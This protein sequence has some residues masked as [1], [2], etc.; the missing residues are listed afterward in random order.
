MVTY[1][2]KD[3]ECYQ[4]QTVKGWILAFTPF[5]DKGNYLLNPFKSIQ[6]GKKF[7]EIST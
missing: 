1:G 7:G 3:Y 2:Y 6:K 5:N 4:E